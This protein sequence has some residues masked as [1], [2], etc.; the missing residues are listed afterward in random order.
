MAFWRSIQL[1]TGLGLTN[2]IKFQSCSAI[3]VFIDFLIII[4][5]DVDFIKNIDVL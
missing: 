5:S 4:I 1:W 2:Q 3:M